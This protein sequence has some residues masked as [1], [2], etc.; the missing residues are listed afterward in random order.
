MVWRAASASTS[1][2]AVFCPRTSGSVDIERCAAC[3]FRRGAALRPEDETIQC[4]L[5]AAAT[6]DPLAS[7]LVGALL[8]G[9]TVSVDAALPFAA[10]RVLAVDQP[11]I[12]IVDGPCGHYVGCIDHRLVGVALDLPPRVRAMLLDTALVADLMGRTAPIAES[13]TVVQAA[14]AMARAHSRHLPVVTSDGELAGV[15][16][17][18]DL[19]LVAARRAT[20]EATNDSSGATRAA[21][22]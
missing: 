9:P 6:N 3:P 21:P 11:L 8:R 18:V 4:E 12:P 7:V 22:L 20:E 5:E 13:A 19:L 1:A 16:R 2:R 14:A 15:V 10:L 17:D